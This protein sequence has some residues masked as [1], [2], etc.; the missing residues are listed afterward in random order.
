MPAGEA[1]Q[2]EWQVCFTPGQDCIGLIVRE[3]GTAKQSILV[4][5]YSFA[6]VP[7]LSA[8]KAAHGCGVDVEVIVDKTSARQSRSGSRYSAATYLT[9]AGIPVWVD[10]TVAIAHN[11]VMVID[12]S[13]VIPAASTSRPRRRSTTPR[14]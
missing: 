13:K 5:A 6:S 12:N 2:A 8:L 11:K 3:I 14:I 9:H 10:T 4:Q 1:G 7:I